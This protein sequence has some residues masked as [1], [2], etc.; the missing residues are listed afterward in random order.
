M[1]EKIKTLV[2]ENKSKQV[3]TIIISKKQCPHCTSRSMFVFKDST[4]TKTKIGESN[5]THE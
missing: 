2:K 4:K 5:E 3:E 1:L